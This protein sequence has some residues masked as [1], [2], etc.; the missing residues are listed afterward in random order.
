M[1][2]D[3]RGQEKLLREALA[4]GV[5]GEQRRVQVA[6]LRETDRAAKAVEAG[7]E[8]FEPAAD[9]Y[10][11]Y[12]EDPR[13]ARGRG[14][15]LAW[16]VAVPLAVIGGIVLGMRWEMLSAAAT[17]IVLLLGLQVAI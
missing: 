15:L 2:I 17:A 9:W 6:L 14:R 13:F 8:P 7:W 4:T 12:V 10:W 3:L 16:G 5:K 11:G 1:A